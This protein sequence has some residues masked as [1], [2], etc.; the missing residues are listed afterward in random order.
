MLSEE[1]NISRVHSGD[2]HD[3]RDREAAAYSDGFR[4]DQSTANALRSPAFH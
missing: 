2:R 1:W 3:P 4:P